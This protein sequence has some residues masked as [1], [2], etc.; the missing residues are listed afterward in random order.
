MGKIKFE[1]NNPETFTLT[2]AQ[3]STL[4][5]LTIFA[6]AEHGTEVDCDVVEADNPHRPHVKF[7]VNHPNANAT[8]YWIDPD[9]TIGM[10][11]EV[12]WD[13]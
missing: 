2:T 9:G 6:E 3:L 4:H 12:D 7:F 1:L 10:S 5:A 13:E 8:R 11:E